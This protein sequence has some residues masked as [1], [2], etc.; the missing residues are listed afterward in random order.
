MLKEEQKGYMEY[1]VKMEKICKSFSGVKVL[2]NVDFMLKPGEIHA[3]VGENG[4]GKSTLV[5]ILSGAYAKDSGTIYIED[6]PVE[7]NSPISAKENGIQC[8]YQELSLVPHL[9]IADNIFLCR[10]KTKNGF[11]DRKYI[12]REAARMFADLGISADVK[13]PVRFVGIGEQFFTEICRCMVGNAKTVIMDEPTSAMTPNEYRNFLKTIK[14]LREKGI[15]VIYISHRLD[16]IFEICDSVTVLRDGK[17][18][19]TRSTKDISLQEMIRYMVGKDVSGYLKRIESRDF[20]QSKVVLKLEN[21]TTHK[22]KNVSLELYEGEVLGVTGLLGAGKTELASALFGTDEVKNGSIYVNGER[23]KIKHPSDAMKKQLALVPEDRKR[24]GLF[25]DFSIKNNISISNLSEMESAKIFVNRLA[26]KKLGDELS[27]K[28]SVK[29][30]NSNQLVKYLSGGNQQK[31]VLA[32]L[33]NRS[34]KILILDEP[35]RGIDVGSKE[36]IYDRIKAL[37]REGMSVLL[38]SSEMPEVIA[39]SHRI[40][41]LHDGEIKGELNGATA[42]QEDILLAATGGEK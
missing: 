31:V 29:C 20:S 37:A 9:S 7:I 24:Q 12:N 21:V 2:D 15:S 11:I 25:Q 19:T 8:I 5:K 30:M 26:E 32:K 40:V 4:A 41:V 39:L 3:L 35:T 27:K 28:F 22:L 14:L 18:V 36:E 16:E 6:K 23:V 17:I 10:E 34:P 38:L 13:T 1:A 42:T 33:I